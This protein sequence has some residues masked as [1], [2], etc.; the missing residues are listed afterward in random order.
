MKSP[1]L[2]TCTVVLLS[3]SFCKKNEPDTTSK[4]VSG[5]QATIAWQDCAIYTD[6]DVTICFTGINEYRCPCNV[7]CVWEG[8]VDATLKVTTTSGIDTTIVLTT[9][10]NPVGLNNSATIGGKTIRFVNTDAVD[11]ADY[12]NSEKYKVVIAVE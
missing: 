6:H 5:S 12:G 1:I 11:C 2:L 4:P 7:E 8:A 3:L 10:S 9:N